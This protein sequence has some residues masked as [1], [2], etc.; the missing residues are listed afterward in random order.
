M[1][2]LL[3]LMTQVLDICAPGTQILK[4]LYPTKL[5]VVV[6]CSSDPACLTLR[7]QSLKPKACSSRNLDKA[8]HLTEPRPKLLS[9]ITASPILSSRKLLCSFMQLLASL[10][11]YSSMFYL[12]WEGPNAIR[13][14]LLGPIIP[15]FLK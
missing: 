5:R 1:S 9:S 8:V 7:Q 13:V 4:R 2:N 14:C 6:N 12:I 11:Y 15:P 10:Q 3:T